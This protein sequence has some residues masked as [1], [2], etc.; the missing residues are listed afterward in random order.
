MATEENIID[1]DIDGKTNDSFQNVCPFGL[2]FRLKM[3]FR[4]LI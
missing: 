3:L 1:A 4:L 2:R